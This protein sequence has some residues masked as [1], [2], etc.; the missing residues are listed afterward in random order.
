MIN[1]HVQG[2]GPIAFTVHEDEIKRF[3]LEFQE[4]VAGDARRKIFAFH[5]GQ[6]TKFIRLDMVAS[7]SV[8]DEVMAQL[9]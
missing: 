2:L 3:H 6:E 7:Y 8:P 5:V 1:L 9:S 4:W